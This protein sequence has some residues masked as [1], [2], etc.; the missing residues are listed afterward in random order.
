MQVNNETR[1]SV[2]SSRSLCIG[3]DHDRTGQR[4]PQRNQYVA[5][6]RRYRSYAGPS[7]Q[8]AP[9]QKN[10]DISK[11]FHFT[12]MNTLN[13]NRETENAGN[14]S[15]TRRS[16]EMLDPTWSMA[17][18]PIVFWTIRR[19]QNVAT[20]MKIK[21]IAEQREQLRDGSQR[22]REKL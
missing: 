14:K 10:G 19:R 2:R 16:C 9:I 5:K 4:G 6:G 15:L 18:I 12:G 11:W 3:T 7:I 8:L 1:E 22:K 13:W 17:T 21:N 20:R